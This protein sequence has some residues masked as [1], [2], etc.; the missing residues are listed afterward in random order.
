MS[1]VL[2]QRPMSLTEILAEGFRLIRINSASILLLAIG[3]HAPLNLLRTWLSDV[4]TVEKY[5]ATLVELVASGIK[6]I[7]SLIAL[8]VFI[9]IAYIVEKSLQGQR[10]AVGDVIKFSISRFSDVFWTSFLLFIITVGLTLLLIVPGI[11]WSIYYSF[12]LTIVALRSIKGKAALAYSKQLVQGQ[13]WRIFG[14]SSAICFSAIIINMAL[15]VYS[16]R[17][18]DM[19]FIYI[20][21][22]LTILN[23]VGAVVCVMVVILFLNAES[24]RKKGLSK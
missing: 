1:N 19:T 5:G 3:A 17:L 22:P 15:V 10:L 18:S 14:I 12:A 23:M 11:I 6:W 9:S 2:L 16:R 20:F 24:V 21:T 13:W 4:F 7:D 8:L